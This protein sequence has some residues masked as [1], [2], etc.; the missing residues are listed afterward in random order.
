LTA[1]GEVRWRNTTAW[2]S[3]WASGLY[4]RNC[5]ATRQPQHQR[6]TRSVQE[7]AEQ[8]LQCIYP[9]WKVVTHG[10]QGLRRDAPLRLLVEAEAEPQELSC[11]RSSDR[12]LSLVHREEVQFQARYNVG[13]L[14]HLCFHVSILRFHGQ[15]KVLHFRHFSNLRGQRLALMSQKVSSLELPD[16]TGQSARNGL[17]LLP[18]PN[19]LT[20]NRPEIASAFVDQEWLT[21][22]KLHRNERMHSGVCKRN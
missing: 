6:Q 14:I 15:F 17:G 18:V 21:W 10:Q 22:R 5:C 4:P 9:D 3:S 12:T 7:A 11:F 20:H 8:L 13:T 16:S 1:K 2:K 19:P